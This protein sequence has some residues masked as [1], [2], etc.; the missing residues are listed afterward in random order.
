MTQEF[1]NKIKHIIITKYGLEIDIDEFD[2]SKP[3]I[4][5][6]VG[7]DSI[8][9]LELVLEIEKTLGINIDENEINNEVLY[10][11]INLRNYLKDKI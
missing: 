5:Y 3:F 11:F 8:A 4:E 7:L 2:E 10:N 1:I 9:N 6:G